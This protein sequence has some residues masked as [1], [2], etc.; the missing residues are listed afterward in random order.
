GLNSPLLKKQENQKILFPYYP[1]TRVEIDDSE[2]RIA[3]K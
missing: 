1:D 3:D 2:R